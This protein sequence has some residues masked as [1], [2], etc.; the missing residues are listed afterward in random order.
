MQDR[1]NQGSGQ[2]RRYTQNQ[3]SPQDQRQ[4]NNQQGLLS[5]PEGPSSAPQVGCLPFYFPIVEII[6]HQFS[7]SEWLG[8]FPQR[9]PRWLQQKQQQ[10]IQQQSPEQ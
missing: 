3:N 5:R 2:S 4:Q 7:L 8:E 10:S 6:Y 1:H 9:T